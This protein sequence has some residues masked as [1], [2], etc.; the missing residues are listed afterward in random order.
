M[1]AER[2]RSIAST[3]ELARGV[4]M[5]RRRK[6]KMVILSAVVMTTACLALSGIGRSILRRTELELR[7]TQFIL[8]Q[9]TF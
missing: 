3:V 1:K 9:T 2:I 8:G 5:R 4:K 7:Q 6:R